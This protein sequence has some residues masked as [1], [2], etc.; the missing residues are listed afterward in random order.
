[1]MKKTL[2]SLLLLALFAGT[3]QAN[4][5]DVER[6]KTLGIKF[7][8][9]NTA[10]RSNA[11][12]LVYT[13]YADNGTACFYVFSLK[14]RGFVIVSADD[15][16]K[17]ILGYSSERG[18][19]ANDIPDGLQSFFTNYQAGFSQMM[20]GD[21]SR[22]EKAVSDWKRLEETGMVNDARITR[23][24][25]QM[26]TSIWNQSA[27][28]N[29]YCPEDT[30]GPDGHVY[31]G[32]VATAM[33]QI[34][35]YWQW[36]RRGVGAH[37]YYCYPYNQ[38]TAAFEAVEYR[39]DLMPDF[40]DWTSTDAEIK[41]VAE[42][43]YHAGVS[44][45]MQY[46]PN[47]S[48]AFSYSV[49]SALSNYFK[50]DMSMQYEALDW[51]SMDEWENMLRENLDNGMPLYYSAS[52]SDGGHAFVCDGYD[53]NN[54]FH[55]N[56]GWQG[57]DNGYYTID[58]FYLSH[59]SFPDGHAAI[60]G[61]YPD[62]DYWFTPRRIEDLHVEAVDEGIN[63][64][65]FVTPSMTNGDF[66]IGQID[67]IV[68]LR[69]NE[70]IH[71]EYG[72]PAGSS[73]SYDDS[74]AHGICHYSLLPYSDVFP[75]KV[76]RDTVLNGPTCELTFHL[77]DSVGDGWLAQSISL[78]DSR[79]IAVK[80]LGLR[81]GDNAVVTVEVPSGEEMALHWA[82]TI[83][84]RDWESY[85]EVNDWNGSLIY[86]TNGMPFVGELCRFV[87]DCSDDVTETAGSGI[88]IYPNPTHSQVTVTGADIV[89]VDVFNIQGQMV[90]SG[91]TAVIDLSSLVNG[92]YLVRVATSDGQV[93][94][95]KVVKN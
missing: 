85:F 87:S 73:F 20:E 28:Y 55:F 81:E 69:N 95:E 33:S 51:Y 67:T 88:A 52:G 43:Q 49:V 38:I 60:F 27:L 6:A 68:F 2:L 21:E 5:V 91:N 13:E 29:R 71:R 9:C 10:I 57:L 92:I 93:W 46:G 25:P 48:G 37:S 45:D 24:V 82:Y 26:L 78:V 16:A 94:H 42:L 22:T 14:P 23:E 75:G 79:G 50:Y 54:M 84:G 83:G 7:M 39:F 89:Q 72:V 61:I 90:M 36:P 41:A 56:W 64:I 44:V 66:S 19:S 34:M 1:M 31:A 86:A 63:R 17:P 76:E 70:I 3:L 18:F 65:S 15:R 77:H 12:D 80:R 8:N 30:L 58:G 62:E 4:P 74:N 53:D 11:A 35:Y 47:G 59:Y 40:L 32:C